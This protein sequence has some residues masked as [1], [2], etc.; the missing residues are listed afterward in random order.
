VQYIMQSNVRK[1]EL[2]DGKDTSSVKEEF[3]G[4]V[5]D[6]DGNNKKLDVMKGSN[7]IV[8]NPPSATL[9]SHNKLEGDVIAE[10][11]PPGAKFERMVKHIK[12]RIFQ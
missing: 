3:L 1:V 4:E 5:K 6:K 12:S 10:K 11:A 7:K 9:V 2:P 8:V